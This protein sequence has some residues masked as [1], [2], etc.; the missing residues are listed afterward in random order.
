[1]GKRDSRL[2]GAVSNVAWRWREWDFMGE[3]KGILWM[4]R[5]REWGLME[6]M[7]FCVGKNTQHMGFCGEKMGFHVKKRVLWRR[8][9]G[10]DGILWRKNGG[11]GIW[12][13][14]SDFMKKRRWS[15]WDFVD[16]DG[17][18]G[19]LWRKK[20]EGKEIFMEKWDFMDK[21]MDFMD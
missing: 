10:A 16:K 18:N 20:D 21:K 19:I 1:M 13:K 4:K 14:K 11:N 6:K 17:E 12:Q 7:G 5:W 8:E 15:R 3:N 2:D 9:H